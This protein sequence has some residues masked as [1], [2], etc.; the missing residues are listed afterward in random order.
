MIVF[1]NKNKNKKK[2]KSEEIRKKIKKIKIFT[3]RLMKSSIVGDYSSAFKGSG[4]EFDQL[5]DYTLGDDIR[6]IDW[7][8]SAR[9]NKIMVREL[10]EERDR[11]V[12]LAIDVSASSLFSSKDELKK[13]MISQVGAALALIAQENKDKVGV[14]FFTDKVEKWIPP[15]RGDVHFAQIL[16]M[17][18]SFEPKNKGT[19]L[20]EALNFLV[21]LKKRNSI[22][23]MF[24]DWID[25][26]SDYSKILKLANY[27][28]DFVGIRFLDDCEKELSDVGLLNIRD[29]ET[30]HFLVIDTKNKKL[31]ILLKQRILEQKKIFEKNKIDT[32]DLIVG[33]PFVN[34]LINFFRQRIRRQI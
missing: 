34:P 16:E 12:I 32:L 4:L 18:F 11:T 9:M 2:D 27:E 23:F 1:K 6:F 14:L 28:Y 24:S 3:K 26:T 20:Q 31:D 22:V 8:S 5:R 29:L 19:N 15:S 7:N 33:R 25:I 21:G 17:I 13:D 10:I 30:D